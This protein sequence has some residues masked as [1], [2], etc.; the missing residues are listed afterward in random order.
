MNGLNIRMKMTNDRL[1]ELEDPSIEF[2]S[3]ENRGII[4]QTKQY[5]DSGII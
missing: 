3:M 4:K 5:H 2:F 1:N